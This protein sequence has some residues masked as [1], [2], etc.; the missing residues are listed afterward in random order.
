MTHAMHGILSA[1]GK[2]QFPLFPEPWQERLPGNQCK[3]YHRDCVSFRT[4]RELT[5]SE[6]ATLKQKFEQ[7]CSEENIGSD[8][9]DYYG[10]TKER[11]KKIHVQNTEGKTILVINGG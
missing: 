10:C 3:Y 9:A 7:L 5:Y 2:D 4:T 1:Q 6:L 11:Q 8:V